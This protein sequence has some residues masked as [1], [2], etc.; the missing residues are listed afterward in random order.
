MI[1]SLAEHR[2]WWLLAAMSGVL[3]L[4]V[5]D[6]TVVTVSLPS[7]ADEL[8]LS[9]SATHWVVNA[10]LLSFTC[11]VALAGRLGDHFSRRSYFTA[12][13]VLFSL[14]SFF[15]AV[16]TDGA[17]LI[18]ARALQGVAAAIIFPTSIAILTTAFR[19]EERGVAF[20]YQTTVGAI[21][22]ASGPLIGGFLTEVVSWRMIFWIGIPFVFA[23]GMLLWLVWS[24]DYEAKRN[25]KSLVSAG[26]DKSGPVFL[27]LA[28]LA[29]VTSVMQGPDWGWLSPLTVSLF[30]FG[31]A[32]VTLFRHWEL[33]HPAP[34]LDLS[35]LKI[36]D[37]RGGVVIF[38]IFQFEKIALFVFV[39]QFLQ[40]TVGTSPIL[41]GAAVSLAILPTLGT[42][43]IIGKLTDRLGARRVV[44]IGAAVHGAA[45]L[46]LAL[47]SIRENYLLMLIPLLIWGAS[48]P[49]IAIP[50]RREQ[51]NSVPQEKHGQASGINL[52]LQMLGGSMG[53]AAM[54]AL[55]A[56]TQSYA[57]LF[58]V[59][60]MITLL[61]LPVA[62]RTIER[63]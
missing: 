63:S 18:A 50:V 38:A 53:L 44:L 45:I 9:V 41:S 31:C 49:S 42:S 11:A 26:L 34:I 10:Y 47:A 17:M 57:I 19:P 30:L 62:M 6:E 58:A 39:A 46:L 21:F 13:A 27:I 54:S 14:S 4:I 16:A 43:I 40:S 24:P 25:G 12:G 37:F 8:G 28:L 59:V 55:H 23:I 29:L 5:F 61:V 35:L 22:M 48:M 33:T 60:G 32:L 20:G 52:T 51:M 56:E 36:P 2:K 15:A 7:I 1:G 3:G